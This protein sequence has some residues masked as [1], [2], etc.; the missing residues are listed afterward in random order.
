MIALKSD[1]WIQDFVM[2]NGFP[3]FYHFHPGLWIKLHSFLHSSF[4]A[5]IEVT[6]K[7]QNYHLC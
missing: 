7:K 4:E 2:C 3:E 5:G 1:T 6:P